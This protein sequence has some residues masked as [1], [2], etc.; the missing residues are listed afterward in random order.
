MALELGL[1][2]GVMARITMRGLTKY[3]RALSR[4]QAG[5]RE[6]VIGAAVYKGADIAA[7]AIRA[8]LEA[9]PTDE[10]WG[11]ES[12][13]ALGPKARQKAALLQTL[14]ISKLR[15]DDGLLN[16]KIGFSGY[17]SIKTKR[18]PQGQ[19]NAMVA[20]SVERGTSFMQASPFIK[21]AMS[22]VSRPARA[23][24][25][26]EVEAKIYALMEQK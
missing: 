2:G 24:M 15:D 1:G 7:D 11:T 5:A 20:R 9:V 6:G 22:Q 18:W 14:G 23:A 26:K 17:N 4:L 19:P 25:K 10:A 13:P 3:T 16:V 8:S 12:S 21:T